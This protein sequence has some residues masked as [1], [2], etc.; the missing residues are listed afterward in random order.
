VKLVILESPNKTSK[1]A[2]YLGAGY[3]V[4]ATAGHFRDLP[5]RE[6]GVD[7]ATFQPT[8]VVHETKKDLVARLKA[9]A[10]QATAVL[11][12]TD[13]DREGEAISWHLA[14]EL[15][16]RGP[17]RLRYTEITEKGIQAAL[18]ALSPLDQH[19]VDAQ[20]ARRV[21]DRLVGYQ[22]SPQLRIFGENHSAGRVQTATLHLVVAREM[23]R[24]AFKPSDYWTLAAHYKNSLVGR[25]ATFDGEGKLTDTRLPTAAEAEAIAAV[26]RSARHVVKTVETAPKERRPAAPFTTSTIQQAASSRL[27]LKPDATM[28]LLQ[29]LFEL[30]AITYHRTDS[31]ALSEDAITMARS[32]IGKDYPVALPDAPIRYKAKADAQGAH[33]AIRPTSL[34]PTQ[35]AQVPTEASALYDLIRRRFIACQCKPA[36]FSQTTV[37]IEAGTTTWR[38]VGRVLQF[39]SFLRYL[40]DD[41]ADSDEQEPQL[42]K[43]APGD[44]LD[45]EKID[46]DA[47]QTKPPSRYTQAT[48]IR[49]MEQTGIGRPSTY[50]NTVATLF[51]RAYIAEEKKFVFPT[52]R[53]RLIDSV[54]GQAYPE[55]LATSTTAELEQRLDDVADGKK[56]WTDV[57]RDWYGPFAKKLAAAGGIFASIA[58]KNPQLAAAAPSTPKPSG[59]KCPSC[60]Q[61]LLLRKRKH[62]NG[63]FL[64]CSAYPTCQY[65]ADPAAKL[66]GRACPRC[67]RELLLISRSDGE[68]EY[69]S[70]SGRSQNQRGQPACS[71]TADPSAK[72]SEHRCP[73]CSGPMEELTG[74]L[75]AYARCLKEGCKGTLDLA[76][77]TEEKCPLC[78]NT[79]RDKGKF[80]GCS[81]YPTCKG[82]LDKESLAMARKSGKT[83]P[84]DGQPLLMRKG[85]KG[86]FLG[87]AAYPK[88]KYVAAT[89]TPRDSARERRS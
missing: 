42:P 84:N 4:M 3:E 9:K 73:T 12:A 80:Y 65:T 49:A 22:V 52:E 54:L 5:E 85:P 87:C 56:R 36:L 35:E 17:M 44:V 41:P 60:G 26:A 63:D 27:G 86:P 11:L 74:K 33:E 66:A 15:R 34:E 30:G 1:V 88:C 72:P 39:D 71:Y 2:H 51:G 45:L 64:A 24:E 21:L 7:T 38:A 78:G 8:Y 70:C 83:C 46:V 59:K 10:K 14:Q 32:F 23:E 43:V 69:L 25:Y 19:L 82:T 31:V 61:E 76:P 50:A 57:I 29:K 79:M 53:G 20:Q 28:A 13:A 68:G 37:T 47:R 18:A 58:A 67:Q 48:L 75:G 77:A 6:L 55:L 40:T 16:L 62:G 81:Q 89:P